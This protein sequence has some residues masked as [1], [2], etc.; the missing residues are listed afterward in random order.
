ML[1]SMKLV[2]YIRVSTSGQ[3]DNTSLTEQRRRIQ[4]Y[5]DAFGHELVYVFEGSVAKM[6]SCRKSCGLN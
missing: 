4:A 2:G 1:L 5:C 3:E 6:G